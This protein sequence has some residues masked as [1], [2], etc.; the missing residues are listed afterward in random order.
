LSEEGG[1]DV[2]DAKESLLVAH[3]ASAASLTPHFL[4]HKNVNNVMREKQ[5]K[6][7]HKFP[8]FMNEKL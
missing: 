2:L 6:K 7:P 1:A 4:V 5:R 8:N 3:S